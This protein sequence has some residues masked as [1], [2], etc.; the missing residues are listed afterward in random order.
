MGLDNLEYPCKPCNDR[1]GSMSP[2]EFLALLAF[3]G[4]DT[5]GTD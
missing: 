5:T 4:D 3:L 1:K 2:D